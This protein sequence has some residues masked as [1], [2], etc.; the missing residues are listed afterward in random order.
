LISKANE[1]HPYHQGALYY[2]GVAAALTNRP[3]EAV[4]FLREAILINAQFDLGIEDL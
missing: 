3:A 1:L 4:K 2:R